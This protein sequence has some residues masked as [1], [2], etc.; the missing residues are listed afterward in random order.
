MADKAREV[1]CKELMKRAKTCNTVE[2]LYEL[3]QDYQSLLLGFPDGEKKDLLKSKDFEIN[4]ALTK[5]G[6]KSALTAAAVIYK[7]LEEMLKHY[8]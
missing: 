3:N 2:R 8:E 1:L 5:K 4:N 7:N 6:S